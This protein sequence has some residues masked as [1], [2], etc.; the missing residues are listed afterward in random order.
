VTFR[1]GVSIT[2][3]DPG[4]RYE[5]GYRFRDQDD[6]VADLVFEGLTPPVP[7]LHGSPPFV[8]S[9]HYDQHGRV[10][11]TLRLRGETVPVDHFAVRDRSWGRRPELLGRRGRLSYAFGTA[12]ENEA[13]LA[14]CLPPPGDPWSTVEHL[15][16]GYLLRDGVLRRLAS[17]TRHVPARHASN[18]PQRIELDGTDTDGRSFHVEGEA[19]S[20]MFL[21]KNPV[22]V[23]TMI[24]WD[25]DGRTAWGEDQD[26]W[27]VPMLGDLARTREPQKS[28]T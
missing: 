19:V 5:L 7:H 21:P 17:A 16:T 15:S 23:N 1:T 27:P 20:R 18:G 9:S 22:C 26:L 14:F 8:G 13:F 11:G 6:F 28:G 2:V 4:M 25:L 12:S 10:R 3:L 24:R